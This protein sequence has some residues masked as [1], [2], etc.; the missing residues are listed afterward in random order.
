MR[1]RPIRARSALLLLAALSGCSGARP[2]AGRQAWLVEQ[3][4]QDNLVWTSRD[5]ALLAAKY[6]KMAADPYD[7]M[8]GSLGVYYADLQR[9]SERRA[10]TRFVSSAESGA[11]LLVGDPHPEN[12]GTFLPDAQGADARSEL[13][14]LVLDFNDLD[15]AAFG[16][17]ILD[18]RRAAVG[19]GALTLALEGCEADCRAEAVVA[20]AEGYTAAVL[21]LDELSAS[22][23]ADNITLKLLE[24]TVEDGLERKR[25]DDLTAPGDDGQRRFLLD[26]ALDD[27]GAGLL[28]LSDEEAAQLD[29]LVSG[30]RLP[31][32][33]RALDGARRYGSGV[34]SSPAVRYVVL[35]DLGDEGDLDDE[36]IQLREV[37][38]PPT[39]PSLRPTLPGLFDSQA[40]RAEHAPRL[41]WSSPRL[42]PRLDAL[43]DGVMTFK[44]LS[45]SSWF[46]GYNHGDIAEDWAEGKIGPAD[47]AALARSVGVLL[48]EAHLRAPTASGEDPG[49]TLR[50]ELAQPG[51]AEELLIDAEADLSQLQ[52]DYAH[53]QAALDSLGPC[54]GADELSP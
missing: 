40:D 51:L 39:P 37:T 48:G 24:D 42:D 32:G 4:V 14:G 21:G 25:L 12:V 53:F 19:I 35:Y 49:P 1:T 31:P 20:L 43:S 46:D 28:A 22:R 47:L 52:A 33:A 10:T 44:V 18:L 30:L 17:W 26:E 38:D 50:A 2:D 54:L 23:A 9:T 41:L 6:Q 3:L 29:R 36:L 8:R 15:G 16:P 13:P 45:Y 11:V 7:F 34:A 27:D 5:P